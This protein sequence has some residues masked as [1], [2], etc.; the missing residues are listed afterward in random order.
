MKAPFASWWAAVLTSDIF[1]KSWRGF[2]RLLSGN[3]AQAP[4]DVMR[5]QQRLFR[6]ANV[7]QTSAFRI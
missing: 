4:P 7:S 5:L 6:G 2:V 1:A 3:A